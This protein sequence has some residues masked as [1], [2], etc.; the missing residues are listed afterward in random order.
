MTVSLVTGKP[1]IRTQNDAWYERY[2]EGADI[3][4]KDAKFFEWRGP[5]I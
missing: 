4:G 3:C 5:S 1:L 2:N